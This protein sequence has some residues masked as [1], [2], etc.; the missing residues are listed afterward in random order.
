MFLKPANWLFSNPSTVDG[1]HQDRISLF[2]NCLQNQ[3]LT[4]SAEDPDFTFC[5]KQTALIWVPCA[6]VA[7][8]AILDVYVRSKSRYSDIPWSFLNVSK[9]LVLVSLICLTFIDLSMMLSVR[10]DDAVDIYNVQIVSV[11]VK[12]GTFVSLP[13]NSWLDCRVF[14]HK[15]ISIRLSSRS[16]NWCTKWKATCHR[17]CCSTFGWFS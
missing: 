3:E 1:W 2:L 15:L 16:S 4:W 13:A 7:L 17:D 8:F 11:S 9:S 5:F 6:F 14:T 12:A 10:S